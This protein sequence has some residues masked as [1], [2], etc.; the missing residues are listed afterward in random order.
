[1][2][3]FSDADLLQLL[4]SEFVNDRNKAMANLYMNV[5]LK[6]S[7]FS[8]LKSRGCNETQANDLFK[9]GIIALTL[10]VK[11]G[12]YKKGNDLKGYLYGICKYLWLNKN[13][14]KN[15]VSYHENP[16]EEIFLPNQ[17]TK[18]IL[19]NNKQV[20]AS[21]LDLLQKNCKEVLLYWAYGYK[22]FEIAEK[23]GLKSEGA[24]RKKKHI[25]WHTLLKMLKSQ[26]ELN[27]TLKDLI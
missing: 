5:S 25:C 9:D 6:D 1:M 7:I 20:V 17:V 26:P 2:K 21:I 13:R 14:L 15:E 10:A 19:Q 22:F 23:A 16:P 4:E 8:F 12:N 11:K 24:A 3:Q 18:L 27:K